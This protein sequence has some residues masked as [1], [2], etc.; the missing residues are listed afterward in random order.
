MMFPKENWTVATPESQGLASDAV[1]AAMAHVASVAV[2]VGVARTLVVRNGVIVWAGPD[3]DSMQAVHSC[4]KSFLSLCLGLLWDDGK[5]RP[6][7][8]ACTYLPVLRA[9]YPGVT[10]AHLATFTSGYA[11]AGD[12][13]FVPAEPMYA[14]GA[15]FHYSAQSDLLA[16]L[17]THVAREPLRDLFKRRIA[18]PI[19]LA[20]E[21]WQWNVL[22]TVDGVAVHGGS[23]FPASGV[24]ITP[25]AFA[26]IGWLL[27][28]NGVWDGK[29]LVSSN[30]I[31]AASRVQVP[32]TVPPHDAKA[33]YVELPGCYGLN[34]WVNGTTPAGERMWPHAP[35]DTFAAQGNRNNVCFVIPSWK[36]AIVRLGPDD[37][38][39]MRA[40]DGMFA[41]LAEAQRN[42]T[43]APPEAG[44]P[45]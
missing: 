37:I 6:E 2:K 1:E 15:A 3:V 41:R 20:D 12:N 42:P 38:I 4:T 13:A 25:R 34:W 35:T 9:Q 36:M 33:W 24:H 22:D 14:P 44:C 31:A 32:P 18:D 11:H 45:R 43:H 40:Y 8:L 17:L 5:C 7:D 30:Y 19:G 29:R 23:G 39:N 27:A 10:L 28:N 16:L 21:A 26:R